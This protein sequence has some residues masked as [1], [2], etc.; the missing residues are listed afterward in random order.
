[1]SWRNVV[2]K[3]VLQLGLV[4][5]LLAILVP[6]SAKTIK[7][8]TLSPDGTLWMKEMRAGAEKIKEKTQGRVVIKFYPG[9]V[10]GSDSSVLR[11][12]RIGQLQG[13]AVTTGSLSGIDPDINI[14]G[15]PYL[16]T[17]LEQVDFVRKKMDEGLLKGLEKK[18]FI[19]F[20]YAEGGFTYM[21]SDSELH[22]VND[23]RQQ[24]VWVPEG[25]QVGEAVFSSAEVSPVTLPLSD[26]LTGL[27]TGLVNTVIASPIGAIALQWHTRVGYMVDV[28]LTYLTAILVI[29]KKALSKLNKDDQKVVHE[30]MT[31]AFKRIDA[32]N[33]KDNIAAREALQKQGIEFITLSKEALDEW[34]VIGDKAMHKLEKEN[35]YSDAVYD[36]IMVNV[37]AARKA[38]P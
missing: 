14:Y 15:L 33:R 10:M 19:S 4:T 29:D 36:Q 9:G 23:V 22:T 24:K 3:K 38:H 7:I 16:F 20:G 11:K 27:Q 17:S 34:H 13:G 6:A 26:V 28:P 25:N 1:M 12:I 18:G 2:N 5:M 31:A 35:D 37:E 8:A 21:M 32:G 30:V